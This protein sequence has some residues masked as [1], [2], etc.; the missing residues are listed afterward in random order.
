MEIADAQSMAQSFHAHR[1]C[2]DERSRQAMQDYAKEIFRHTQA[3]IQHE[4]TDRS[5]NV[6]EEQQLLDGAQAT[7]QNGA[8]PRKV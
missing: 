2:L 8:F 6:K 7:T 5:K 3:Q 1:S 4:M